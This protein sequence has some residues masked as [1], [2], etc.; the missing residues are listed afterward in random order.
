MKDPRPHILFITLSNIGD[1]V[2]TTPALE[3]LHQLHPDAVIDIVADRRSSEI[4]S[5]CPYRGA[6]IHKEKKAG[7][8]GL[9]D[10]VRTLRRQRYD[11]VVDLRTDGLAWL[12]RARHRLTKARRQPRGPH[13][14]ED[15]ISIIDAVDPGRIIPPATVWLDDAERERARRWLATLPEGSWLALG[16]GANWPPKIWP[17]EHFE[18]LIRS[19][20]DRFSGLVLLGGPDD[21]GRCARLA[22]D[23]PLPVANLAGETS[24]LEAAAVLEGCTAFV[25]NDSGL[26]HLA[27]AAGTPTLTLFGP[28]RPERYHPWGENTRWLRADET[29]IDRLEA[30][31]VAKALRE[32]LP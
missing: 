20:A 32:M 4:F 17:L 10:L 26:G 9:W 30:E 27:A 2:M 11:L 25:G 29:R 24:L 23:A 22:A 15:L 18:A 7:L 13:A 31:T 5:H 14:V 8:R 3:R 6:I 19:V 1:A 28:G 12:L 21:R 16:P